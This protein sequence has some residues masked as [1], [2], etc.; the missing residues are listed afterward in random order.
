[1]KTNPVR[2]RSATS[3]HVAATLGSGTLE[4]ILACK[5]PRAGCEVNFNSRAL[6]NISAVI[7]QVVEAASTQNRGF[8][9]S[10]NFHEAPTKT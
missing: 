10:G 4:Q 3:T 7:L 5:T 1:M 2:M 6:V 8:K 9:A